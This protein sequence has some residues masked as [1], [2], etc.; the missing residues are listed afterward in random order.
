M[1]LS[2]FLSTVEI[3][4]IK[5]TMLFR[6]SEKDYVERMSKTLSDS[7]KFKKFAIKSGNEI[8]SLLQQDYI[9]TIFWKKVTRYISD[10]L[11]GELYPSGWQ[12]GIMNALSKIH[13]A[14]IRNFPK[15]RPIL[16][17]I[18]TA[19]YGY[20]EFFVVVVVPF[21]KCFTMNEYKLKDLFEYAIC[22][23]N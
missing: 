17:A 9:L 5:I 7:I 3:C 11:Y 16:S 2:S 20:A 19:T 6:K 15:L 23:T 12:P 8:I 13:E 22:K 14:L 10:Q 18:N 21:P 1:T 4:G